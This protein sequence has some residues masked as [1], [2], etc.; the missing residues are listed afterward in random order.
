[1]TQAVDWVAI[2]PPLA[3]VVAALAALL[4][5]AAWPRARVAAGMLSLAGVAVALGF[6]MAG[7][8]DARSTFC[9]AQADLPTSCSWLVDDVTSAWWVIM[10]IATGLVVLLLWPAAVAGELPPGELHF[11]VLSSAAGALAVAAAQD[12]ITLL[13]AMETVSLPAFALVGLRRV[14]RR[15]AEAALKFF[16]ASVVA[17]AL[18]LLG[19]SLVYGATGS[20]AAG[21]VAASIATGTAVT[22]VIGVGMVLTVVALG[23][24]VAAVPFQVWV[25]DTY[26]GAP[27]PV[28]GY[29]SVVSK[30]A[31]LAGLTI[32]LVRFLSAYV[33]TW[34][35]MIGVA[36]ALTMTVGNLGALRQRH[37]V[38]LLAWS[39]VAQ[40][41]YLL[42]PL[43]A[44]GLPEDVTALQAY[45]LMYAIVNLTAFAAALAV[46]SW[47]KSDIADCAGLARTHPWIGG[48][49]AFALLCLAGLPPGVVGLIAK[50]AIFRSAVDGDLIW[51]AVVVGVNVAIG[52]VYYLRFL[53]VLVR[54]A[55]YDVADPAGAGDNQLDE[56]WA[57]LDRAV[58]WST[59]FVVGITLAAAVVLSVFP[60]LLFSAIS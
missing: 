47:G 23:F 11:L 29:L 42:V 50:V 3:L 21:P 15:G 25:P 43:A 45:A 33:D 10:L 38:R 1:M 41:G 5:D 30:A 60:G 6:T 59:E 19:I 28:A 34:S 54:P 14:D 39:S 2:A 36:A 56:R 51:L 49:L 27:I 13:V 32:V 58:P 17:T 9:F 46:A 40:A 12:L 57:G 35:T 24:K 44:G 26:V 37:I 20:V 16:I 4:V 48:S 22:P 8:N 18:S 52:L 55:A 53:A 31:G 7:R